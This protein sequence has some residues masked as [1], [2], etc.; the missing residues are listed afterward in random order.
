[1]QGWAKAKW[2]KIQ[3]KHVHD[4]NKEFKARRQ[5]IS[6]CK[7]FSHFLAMGRAITT[8]HSYSTTVGQEESLAETTSEEEVQEGPGMIGQL[9]AQ[10]QALGSHRA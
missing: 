5:S 9:G 1:M 6:F 10:E 4:A 2:M 7:E 3:Y 8:L